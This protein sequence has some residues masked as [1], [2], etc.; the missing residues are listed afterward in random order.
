MSKS[1]RT[2]P[3]LPRSTWVSS[4]CGCACDRKRACASSHPSRPQRALLHLWRRLWTSSAGK[5]FLGND[6]SI[7]HAL[8]SFHFRND[9][10]RLHLRKCMGVD[11]TL[12]TIPPPQEKK[13]EKDISTLYIKGGRAQ[14]K[15]GSPSFEHIV[16]QEAIFGDINEHQ[17]ILLWGNKN[18]FFSAHNTHL[19]CVYVCVGVCVCLLRQ[20]YQNNVFPIPN[21]SPLYAFPYI[22][23]S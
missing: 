14:N 5:D 4:M 21:R 13:K 18:E 16:F 11:S 2:A 6:I 22:P 23:G 1:H 19:V 17:F 15:R 10:T 3:R 12:Q 8:P 9:V 7:L 20:K